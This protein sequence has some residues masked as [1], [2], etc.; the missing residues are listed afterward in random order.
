MSSQNPP[1][2][3]GNYAPATRRGAQV[4]TAGMTPRRDGQL[5]RT[6]GV[7]SGDDLNDYKEAAQLAVANA[8]NAARATLTT[9][10][11]IAQI[12]S[13]TVYVAS[14]D[15]AFDKHSKIADFASDYL[16][17]ELGQEGISSRAAIGV[18]TLPGK[19]PLEI[20]LIAA[21]E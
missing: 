21:I 5:I 20:S 18:F 16:F 12:L 8:L 13:M 6:G 7:Q 4:F 1:I 2:P 17:A 15:E 3:Q 9:N 10:E 14:S 19:A 11:R